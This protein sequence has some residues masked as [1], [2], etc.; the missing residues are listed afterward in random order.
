[1]CI[2]PGAESTFGPIW[3]RKGP[4]NL[5]FSIEILPTVT[6]NRSKAQAKDLRKL[7]K[8]HAQG[9]FLKHLFQV[10]FIFRKMP[11]YG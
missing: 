7:N 10:E 9:I 5:N 2:A 3:M 8:K 1:M 6:S 11:F 4:K